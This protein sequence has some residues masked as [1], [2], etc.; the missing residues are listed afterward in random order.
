LKILKHNSKERT[1]LYATGSDF[2]RI[3]AEDMKSLYFLSLVLTADSG[4]AEQCVVS[5]LDDCHAGNQVFREWARSWARRVVIKNAIRIIFSDPG[6]ARHV[7]NA[8][9]AKTV[10][11]SGGHLPS[12][13]RQSVPVELS[14]VLG[15]PAFERFAFVMSVLEGYSPS[16]CALLLG[17]TRESL[18]VARTRALEFVG[19]SAEVRN[20]I[21]AGKGLRVGTSADRG[22]IGEGVLRAQLATPA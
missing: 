4:K 21:Q 2:C 16:D 10:S 18:T 11:W 13:S 3:F 22:A 9:A 12:E 1:G 8:A 17:C 19:R 5:G 6:S 14:V 15:L 20:A 7:L